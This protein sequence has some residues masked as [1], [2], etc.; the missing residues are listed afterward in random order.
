MDDFCDAQLNKAVV[1]RN[2]A[3][4]WSF[5]GLQALH[6]VLAGIVASL[7]LLFSV[8]FGLNMLYGIAVFV[9]ACVALALLQ[10]RR[11]QGSWCVLFIW[12]YTRAH[13]LRTIAATGLPRCHP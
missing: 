4:A 2:L 13:P 7:V 11:R 5:Y 6:F 12:R 8:V 10:W 9:A 3:Y 1:H